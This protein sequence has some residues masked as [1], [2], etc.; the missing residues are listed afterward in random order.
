MIIPI[1][2]TNPPITVPILVI[3]TFCVPGIIAS[4]FFAKNAGIAPFRLAVHWIV[5]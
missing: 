4:P 2:K 1:P 5:P 3:K